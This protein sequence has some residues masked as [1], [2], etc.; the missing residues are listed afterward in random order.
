MLER[1]KKLLGLENAIIPD[2]EILE[3]YMDMARQ[4]ACSFCNFD[5]LSELYD[6]TIVELALYL[7][8][9]K[10]ELNVKSK[11]EGERSASYQ[12]A[13]GIPDYIKSAL[14]LPRVRV[15]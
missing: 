7:F 13:N 4:M 10:R 3:Y 1:M 14:P 15:I 2:D 12:V 5:S 9:N 6:N 11:T 8:L